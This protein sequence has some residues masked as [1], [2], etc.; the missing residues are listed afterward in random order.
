MILFIFWERFYKRMSYLEPQTT[1]YKWLF[2]LDDSQ[3]LHRK[4]LFHQTS[5]FKWLFGVPGMSY[6]FCFFF[7]EDIFFGGHWNLGVNFNFPQAKHQFPPGLDRI[8]TRL[9]ESNPPAQ[10]RCPARFPVRYCCL[11][12]A[13]KR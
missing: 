12:T 1:I 7:C 13:E 11:S 4:W 9:V 6:V 8:G 10:T 5:I 3:S 2:Q